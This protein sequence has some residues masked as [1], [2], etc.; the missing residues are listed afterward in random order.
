[1]SCVATRS[2]FVSSGSL[3]CA[4]VHELMYPPP[5]SCY[6]LVSGNP[7]R[8]EC[9]LWP[10]VKPPPAVVNTLLVG[11]AVLDITPPRAPCP[12]PWPFLMLASIA[13]LDGLCTRPLLSV[14]RWADGTVYRL[15]HVR[16]IRPIEPQKTKRRFPLLC[17]RT[18]YAYS[19]RKR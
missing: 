2:A 4:Y 16:V 1:M 11:L 18:P 5:R 13:M 6:Y 8:V 19:A 12:R 7:S 3:R 14:A 10:V 9:L 15:M 17:S